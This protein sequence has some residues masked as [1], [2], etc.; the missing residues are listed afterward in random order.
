MCNMKIHLHLAA[1]LDLFHQELV[2]RMPVIR[3]ACYVAASKN[4]SNVIEIRCFKNLQLLFRGYN[5]C[6]T[7]DIQWIIYA[8]NSWNMHLETT[9]KRGFIWSGHLNPESRGLHKTMMQPLKPWKH[10][11]HVIKNVVL[12]F[13]TTVTRLYK[14]AVTYSWMFY[15][16]HEKHIL[17]KLY[18]SVTSRP[19]IKWFPQ[20]HDAI[21]LFTYRVSVYSILSSWVRTIIYFHVKNSSKNRARLLIVFGYLVRGIK[22]GFSV[23]K[24]T[25]I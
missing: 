19:W 17:E 12:K 23:C 22:M 2:L 1:V 24:Q 18:L 11:F 8:S 9:G 21:N 4:L 7:D 15:V 3:V 13:T 5:Q 10:A 16:V 20:S 25:N 14:H 6:A